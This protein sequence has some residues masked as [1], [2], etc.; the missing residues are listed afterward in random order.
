MQLTWQHVGVTCVRDVTKTLMSSCFGSW[1][2]ISFP[3]RY[4]QS[5][6]TV[7][8]SSLNEGQNCI[9]FMRQTLLVTWTV[10]APTVFTAISYAPRM[11]G[12]R[13]VAFHTCGFCLQLI[14]V[15]EIASVQVTSDVVT[16]CS[17]QWGTSGSTKSRIWVS[18]QCY[19]TRSMSSP[20]WAFVLWSYWFKRHVTDVS[21]EPAVFGLTNLLKTEAACSSETSVTICRTTQYRNQ[22]VWRSEQVLW[23]SVCLF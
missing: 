3:S 22:D 11:H 1:T 14:G 23:K 18:C 15:R 8:A 16:R 20:M 5:N 19:N 12:L 9:S 10:V 13:S 4:P 7:N 21:E 17:S 2:W 6:V